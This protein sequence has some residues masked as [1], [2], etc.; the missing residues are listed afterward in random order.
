MFKELVSIFLLSSQLATGSLAAL[1]PQQNINGTTYLVNRDYPVSKNYIPTVVEVDVKGSSRLLRE[2]GARALEELFAAAKEEEED[3][4][5]TT[6]SGYRSYSKQSTIY[7]RKIDNVGSKEKA[8]QYVAPPGTSEHQLGL[9]MDVGAKGVKVG[10]NAKFGDTV[11]GKWLKEN[12][13][14]F[15]F[16]IR[17]QTGWEEIT[18]YNYEPWH[19]RYVGIPHAT[20]MFEKEIPME[21]YMAQFQLNQFRYFA[22]W[23][24]EERFGEKV[25]D[26]KP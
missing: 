5:F 19:V 1:A 10:L 23:E 26:E 3:I 25:L 13:H 6:T 21:E 8:N 9:A 22:T 7:Q 17:Y 12:A 18:G 20:Y 14:R 15:G 11:P 16:I 4:V 24:G 2:D